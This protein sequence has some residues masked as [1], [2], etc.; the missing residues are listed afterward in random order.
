MPWTIKNYH[1]E[2]LTT[3]PELRKNVATLFRQHAG[4]KSPEVIDLLVY[5]GRGELEVRAR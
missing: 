4:V 3:G 5:K 2:E 1:L